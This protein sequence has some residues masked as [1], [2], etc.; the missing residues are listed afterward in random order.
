[1]KSNQMNTNRGH[2]GCGETGDDETFRERYGEEIGS[3]MSAV[4]YA[5]NGIAAKVYREGQPRR[6][7]FQEAFTL[8]AVEESGVPVPKVYGVETFRGRTALLMDQAK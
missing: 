4:I 7:V 1:M 3:G 6:Q 5:R 2:S 8:A